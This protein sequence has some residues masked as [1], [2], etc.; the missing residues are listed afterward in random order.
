[1]LSVIGSCRMH[2]ACAKP[3][4]QGKKVNFSRQWGHLEVN[5]SHQ[6]FISKFFDL[7]I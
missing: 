4:D 1:M 6:D 2:V 5:R 7:E 3:P